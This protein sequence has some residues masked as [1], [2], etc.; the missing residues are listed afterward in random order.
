MAKFKAKD[1]KNFKGID[2]GRMGEQR[3]VLFCGEPNCVDRKDCNGEI[4][5]E[6]REVHFEPMIPPPGREELIEKGL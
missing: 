2:G 4:I 6:I 5:E 3:I 1:C